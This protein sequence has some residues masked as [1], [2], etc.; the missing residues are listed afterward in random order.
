S[1]M[2]RPER[3]C[4]AIVRRQARSLTGSRGF[5]DRGAMG[6]L[7]GESIPLHEMLPGP[8]RWPSLDA[9]DQAGAVVVGADLPGLPPV[10]VEVA[11]VPALLPGDGST[12][13]DSWKNCPTP[14]PMHHSGDRS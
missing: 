7:L 9:Y 11:T 8:A 3:A 13:A 1:A 14:R 6:H 2:D 4:S 12:P 10:V 5:P